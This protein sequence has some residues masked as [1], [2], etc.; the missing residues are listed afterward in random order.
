ML[1]EFPDINQGDY[2]HSAYQIESEDGDSVTRFYY[3]SYNIYKG[4]KAIA[5]LPSVYVESEDE[6]M[7]LE[8]T[9]FDTVRLLEIN[10]FYTIYRDYS[11]ITRSSE[12]VNKSDESIKLKRLMSFNLDMQ[13][14]RWD[15]MTLSGSHTNEKIFIAEN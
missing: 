14:N 5:G 11:V 10:L 6:A 12:L 4:K 13:D 9:L 7:T 2:R 15:V 8:L 1:R 3:K